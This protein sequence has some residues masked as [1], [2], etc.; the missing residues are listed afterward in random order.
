MPWAL[1]IGRHARMGGGASFFCFLLGLLFLDAHC[2][3]AGSVH[4]GVQGILG[5][6][7]E[8][9][10]AGGELIPIFAGEIS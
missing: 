2:N 8:F 10:T 7:A 3:N 4:H 5:N 1:P 6:S 9:A